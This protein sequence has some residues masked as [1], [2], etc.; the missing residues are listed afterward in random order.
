MTTRELYEFIITKEISSD[1]E[2]ELIGQIEKTKNKI[3]E[4]EERNITREEV[5]E[6]Q[7][8]LNISLPTTLK[9]VTVDRLLEDGVYFS[10][11]KDFTINE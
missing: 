2:N 8:W 7:V 10:A 5:I 11:F 6:E 4:R 9:D 1:N 3:K